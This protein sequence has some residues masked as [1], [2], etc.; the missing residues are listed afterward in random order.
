MGLW[1]ALLRGLCGDGQTMV[2]QER[3]LHGIQRELCF[4]YDI[5]TRYMLVMGMMRWMD[6]VGC[7]EMYKGAAGERTDD[8]WCFQDRRYAFLLSSLLVFYLSSSWFVTHRVRLFQGRKHK[9]PEVYFLRNIWPARWVNKF[10]IN[11]CNLNILIMYK[12]SKLI[13]LCR[14]HIWILTSNSLDHKI[15][16]IELVT[17]ILF[18]RIINAVLEL[19]NP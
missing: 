6:G 4:R 2:R 13:D 18:K 19:H 11:C 12:H 3:H 5:Y 16:T 1:F 7:V 8:G 9:E 14:S 10:D 17:L 15:W